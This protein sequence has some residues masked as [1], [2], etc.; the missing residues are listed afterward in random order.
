MRT[1]GTRC[2]AVLDTQGHHAAICEAGGALLR[3]HDSGH[4]FVARRLSADLGLVASKEQRCPHW[5]HRRGN[6]TLTQAR[7]DIIVAISGITYYIDITIVDALSDNAAL[8]RQRARKDGAAAED[9]ADAKLRK[10]PGA[11]TIPFVIESYGRLGKSAKDWLRAV[12]HGEPQR[13]QA[14]LNE[15]AAM[16]QSHTSSMILAAYGAPAAGR[17]NGELRRAAVS[18]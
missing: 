17:Q 12:Y 8:L 2:N 18:V 5:D 3:R 11:T 14:L 10:Y 6:G 9:A 16:M 4:D 7:L 13:K 15:L 1:D